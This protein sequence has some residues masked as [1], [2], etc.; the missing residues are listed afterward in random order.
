MTF[1]GWIVVC[2]NYSMICRCDRILFDVFVF[3]YFVC[4]DCICVG[5]CVNVIRLW[6]FRGS[7]RR[8]PC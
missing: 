3:C 4:V 2:D 6:K 5:F 8:L 7:I 1:L